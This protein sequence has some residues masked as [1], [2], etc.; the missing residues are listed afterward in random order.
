MKTL[1]TQIKTRESAFVQLVEKLYAADHAEVRASGTMTA[2]LQEF[3]SKTSKTSNPYQREVFRQLLLHTYNQKCYALL[4]QNL[5]VNVL[6]NISCLGNHLVR[7]VVEW[8]NTEIDAEH[9][10]RALIRHCF[11]TYEV[12]LF[13]ERAFFSEHR[14][15]LLWYVQLGRGN[16]VKGLSQFPVEFTHKMA[17]I[18]RNAPEGLGVGRAIRYAQ[19][20]G[21]GASKDT[22]LALC[23]T[24]LGQFLNE[25]EAFW[26]EVIRF[27]AK[28]DKLIA[29]EMCLMLDYLAEH[30]TTRLKGTTY[31]RLFKQSRAWKKQRDLLTQSGADWQG[32]GI[33]PLQHE[34][35]LDGCPVT[36]QTL[37]LQHV[38]ALYEEGD[39]MQHCV[40]EYEA[41]CKS[42]ESAIFSLQRKGQHGETKRLATVEVALPQKELVQIQG[43]FNTDPTAETLA[44][45]DQWMAQ[46][47]LQWPKDRATDTALA[48]PLEERGIERPMDT[49]GTGEAL[50]AII[51]VV[52]WILYFLFRMSHT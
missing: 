47:Q 15:H 23:N 44:L 5:Y 17:H 1:R 40:A 45:I 29:R 28:E 33:R 3:F 21:Y 26:S 34:T 49:N 25:N 39:I 30:P 14:I 51:K 36:Y 13:M 16:S 52:F 41:E 50:I 20:M 9:Q 31:R 22:A 4:R 7:E 12:P 2:M 24:F 19:A 32:S 27:F 8:K 38:A 48:N 18:F 35:E 42:G 6:Y 43:R 37:E 46:S 10:V 11:A